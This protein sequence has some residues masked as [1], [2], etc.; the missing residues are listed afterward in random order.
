[1]WI[2]ALFIELIVVLGCA[3]YASKDFDKVLSENI[4]AAGQKVA[5]FTYCIV[6][7][8]IIQGLF[9]FALMPWLK[10]ILFNELLAQQNMQL[11]SKVFDIFAVTLSYWLYIR[12]FFYMIKDTIVNFLC[13][14]EVVDEDTSTEP[15]DKNIIWLSVAFLINLAVGFVFLVNEILLQEFFLLV[16]FLYPLGYYLYKGGNDYGILSF[17]K[18]K[19]NWVVEEYIK[20]NKKDFKKLDLDYAEVKT[21]IDKSIDYNSDICWTYW[22]SLGKV[23]LWSLVMAI[24][25]QEAPV[26]LFFY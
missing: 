26:M 19:A 16:L 22:L 2:L 14:E 13:G 20:N 4:E 9:A 3:F 24:V 15:F 17:Y 10:N 5:S 7:T 23:F 8:L 12:L 1:M 18:E 6:I 21:L 11:T 25:F